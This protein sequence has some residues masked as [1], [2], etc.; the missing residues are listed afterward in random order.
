[1]ISISS[2]QIK[3]RDRERGIKKPNVR[4]KPTPINISCCFYIFFLF[5]GIFIV[6]S[7]RF[8]VSSF[9]CEL[10]SFF[11]FNLL[12]VLDNNKIYVKQIK[13]RFYWDFLVDFRYWFYFL[14]FVCFVIFFFV[15][16]VVV[17]YVN[18]SRTIY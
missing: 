13:C 6:I 12:L 2:P 14:F 8:V 5:F 17:G 9:R 4:A 7:I 18:N 10:N 3:S 16:V 11:F 1:M 15:V